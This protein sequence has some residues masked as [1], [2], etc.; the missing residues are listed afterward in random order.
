[1]T[2]TPL[3][4]SES[5]WPVAGL[6]PVQRLRVLAAALPYVAFEEAVVDAPVERVWDFWG[7]LERSTPLIELG[8]S[9]VRIVHRDGDRLD[10]AV[11]NVLGGKM[12]MQAELRF[13]WCVMQSRNTQIG[14]AAAAEADGSKTRLAH[15][16]GSSL[17]GRLA[18]PYFQWN[19]R[20]DLRRIARLIA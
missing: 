20:G 2:E 12:A 16:E 1:M 19:I 14:M 3:A 10:L 5:G 9:T 6:D 17:L 8:V 11:R 7:D 15:F 4:N 18:R 13:G